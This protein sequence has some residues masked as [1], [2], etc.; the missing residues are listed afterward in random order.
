[1]VRLV[2]VSMP[3]QLRIVGLN[4]GKIWVDEDFDEPLANEFW[5]GPT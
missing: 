5:T 4:R 3:N 2:P 1:M